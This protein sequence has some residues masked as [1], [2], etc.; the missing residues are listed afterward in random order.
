MAPLILW[1]MGSKLAGMGNAIL[2][3]LARSIAS[4]VGIPDSIFLG[5]IKTESDWNPAAVSGA[6]AVGLAQVMPW[7]ATNAD[8]QRLSGLQSPT[9]LLDPEKNLR[10]GARILAEE[11]KRFG[12]PALALMAYNGG[13]GAVSTAIRAARSQDPSAVSQYLPKAETRAYWKKV[14]NWAAYYAGEIGESAAR[15]GAASANVSTTVTSWAKNLG[16]GAGLMI[17]AA[18]A[19]AALILGGRK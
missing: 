12:D 16:S 9:E 13:P 4:E 15:A 14:M 2:E 19:A 1:E 11:L 8:G 17:F 7:W 18:I 5:L 6:G 10:A 3:T